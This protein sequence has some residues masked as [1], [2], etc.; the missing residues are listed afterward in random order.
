[1]L[2]GFAYQVAD[3]QISGGPGWIDSARYDVAAKADTNTAPAQV[4]PML[5]SLLA[6]RFQVKVHREIKEVPVYA[7]VVG[8][9]GPKLESPKDG[10]CTSFDPASPKPPAPGQKPLTYCGTIRMGRSSMDGAGISAEQLRSMLSGI[11]GRTVIDETGLKGTFN[12]HLRW[13]ADQST[14]GC[15]ELRE[16]LT[17]GPDAPTPDSAGPSIFTALQEQLGLR[18]ESGKGPVE[19]LVIDRAEKPSDN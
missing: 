14:P 17:S 7:L 2:L 12:V 15:P 9:N 18:L 10:D 6:D 4:M 3:F 11:M 13:R 5:K 19:M 1:M 8:K 16:P